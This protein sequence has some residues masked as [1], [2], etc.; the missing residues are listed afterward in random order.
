MTAAYSIKIDFDK[1]LNRN[2]ERVFE[3]MALFV[4]GF[5]E[6]QSAFIHGFGSK[7]EFHSTLCRTR[8]G[9]CIADITH[10]IQEK[11]RHLNLTELWTCI[12]RGLELSLIHI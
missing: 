8:E 12:Y 4:K 10:D 5:N 6:L 7:I 3:S 2:P 9:S 11:V 1:S